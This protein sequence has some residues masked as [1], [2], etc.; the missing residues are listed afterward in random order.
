MRVLVVE[1][2]ALLALMLED[3]LSDLGCV[4]TGSAET[5][6]QALSR[7]AET[8]DID[9]AILDVH[10]GGETV[11]PVADALLQRRV[12][13][14]FSTGYGPADL[15]VRYPGAPLLAKPYRPEALAEA[16]ASFRSSASTATSARD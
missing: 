14:L 1:D 15:A 11:F 2:E 3:M 10:L 12:P 16:L 4:L 6:A 7:I 9:A 13:F 8:S 5:V